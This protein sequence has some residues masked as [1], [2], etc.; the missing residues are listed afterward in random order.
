[1]ALPCTKQAILHAIKENRKFI[2]WTTGDQAAQM[3]KLD[4]STMM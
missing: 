3:F 4:N 2:G 1:M